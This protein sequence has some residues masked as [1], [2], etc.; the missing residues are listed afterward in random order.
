MSSI[1]MHSR[2]RSPPEMPPAPAEAPVATGE[3]TIVSAALVRSR[4]CSS[5]STRASLS[6]RF[7]PLE[8]PRSPY[9]QRQHVVRRLRQ[10][11]CCARGAR[12]RWAATGGALAAATG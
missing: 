7:H 12:G 5:W 2:L 6:A 4:S 3:P 8:D 10:L 1:A 11:M 9:I